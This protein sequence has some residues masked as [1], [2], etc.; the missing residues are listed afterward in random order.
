[1]TRSRILQLLDLCRSPGMLR[2]YKAC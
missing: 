1:M 2:R